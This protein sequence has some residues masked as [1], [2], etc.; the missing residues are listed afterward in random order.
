MKNIY[1]TGFM[2]AGKTATGRAL[3]GL[4][5]RAFCDSD[6]AVEK[7]TGRSVAALVR[8]KGL[9]GFRLAEARAVKKII[10]RVRLVAALGGGV[11]PSRRWAAGLNSSGVTVYLHCPWPE[12]E[13]R[14]RSARGGRPLLQGDWGQ[15]RLRAKKLYKK[16]LAFYR[17]AEFEINTARLTPL[18]AARK[19]K[20]ALAGTL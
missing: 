18:A 3:A 5:N 13:K 4:L 1:L 15:A 7:D 16:R 19:I 9:A 17:R 10:G 20:R 11:Y 6:L 12:L 14:L 8:A 2:C